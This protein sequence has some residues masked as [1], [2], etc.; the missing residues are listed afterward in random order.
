MHRALKLW[1]PRPLHSSKPVKRSCRANLAGRQ[2]L[3]HFRLR[4]LVQ[5]SESPALQ[6]TARTEGPQGCTTQHLPRRCTMA[7]ATGPFRSSHTASS[8]SAS[9]STPSSACLRVM[10]MIQHPQGHQPEIWPPQHQLRLSSSHRTPGHPSAD[11]RRIQQ[12]KAPPQQRVSIGSP[13]VRRVRTVCL[14]V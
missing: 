1:S 3:Q 12:G 6:A 4:A 14:N 9:A 13:A 2:G 10:L 7:P 11:R 8:L 5:V